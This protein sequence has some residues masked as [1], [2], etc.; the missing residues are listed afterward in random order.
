MTRTPCKEQGPQDR[1]EALAALSTGTCIAIAGHLAVSPLRP[2]ERKCKSAA[3][4]DLNAR[5]NLRSSGG[6]PPAG[7]DR[8]AAAFGLSAAFAG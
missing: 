2:D 8:S 1:D 5:T 6:S 3:G 7:P 4:H